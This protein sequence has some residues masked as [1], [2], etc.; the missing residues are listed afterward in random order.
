MRTSADFCER[1]RSRSAAVAA[2]RRD[3]DERGG[4]VISGGHGI[5]KVTD[6]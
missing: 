1:R 2:N 5:S 6:V 3:F 4:E